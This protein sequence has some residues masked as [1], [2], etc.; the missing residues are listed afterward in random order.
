[1]IFWNLGRCSDKPV[2]AM[3]PVKVGSAGHA[4]ALT[5]QGLAQWRLLVAPQ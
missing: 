1:M 5:A 4:G 3:K 2:G